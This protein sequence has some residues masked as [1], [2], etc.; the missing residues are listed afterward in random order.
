MSYVQTVLSWV[1]T[2]RPGV[3]LTCLPLPNG[4]GGHFN[5]KWLA[6]TAE[7]CLMNHQCYP[8][9]SQAHNRSDW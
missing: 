8:A 5:K 1:L 2:Q 3:T 6:N 4:K 7:Y 9:A